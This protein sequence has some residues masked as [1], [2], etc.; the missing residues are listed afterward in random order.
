MPMAER[1]SG[2]FWMKRILFTQDLG[3][4]SLKKKEADHLV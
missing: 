3:T 4:I 2:L 1:G